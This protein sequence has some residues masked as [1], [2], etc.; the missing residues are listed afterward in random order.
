MTDAGYA[1]FLAELGFP[2]ALLL[3]A[4]LLCVAWKL[5]K[6]ATGRGSRRGPATVALLILVATAVMA[7]AS[8]AFLD[9]VVLLPL[10]M[11]T[12]MALRAAGSQ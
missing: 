5:M 4:G 1:G 3:L 12:G 8:A 10:G 11:F 2:G 9:S 6:E 7:L